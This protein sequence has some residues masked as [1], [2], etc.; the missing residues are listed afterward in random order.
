MNYQ[1]LLSGMFGDNFKIT[2]NDDILLGQ[3]GYNNHQF[4]LSGVVNG[5]QLDNQ[6]SLLLSR[7]IL[8]K[9]ES[10]PDFNLLIIVDTGGQKTTH[11]A[12]LLGLNRYFAH[13]I[14]TIH[15]ARSKGARV[16][17]VVNGKALGGAFIAT[18]LN[19]EKIYALADA[20]IAVMW[21]E[22]MSRVTKIPLQK[23]QELSKT[24]AIFAP[25]AEN[26]VKLGA[27]ESILAPAQIMPQLV[28]DLESA[29][30]ALN[31]WRESG[32]NHGGRIMA[33]KIV[34]KIIDA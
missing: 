19:A 11:H 21:L 8:D 27:V 5:A 14:K 6:M 33:D 25:G 31:Y 20:E 34:K 28:N 4:W 12:E 22:A 3:A 13:L 17:A 23:L 15:L 32:F 29:I 10:H 1:E 24:S 30:P 26:F 16:F 7:Y 9:M 18:A 2:V